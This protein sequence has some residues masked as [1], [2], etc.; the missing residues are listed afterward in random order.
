MLA[1]ANLPKA[2]EHQLTVQD[3]NA[4]YVEAIDDD[5]LEAWPDF[6]TEDGRYRITTAENVAQN[7]PLGMM[8]A[9]SRAM[10]RD[11]V[12][13][14]RDANVYETQRYRHV[15]GAPRVVSADG[16]GIRARTGF[17][18]VRIMHTGE[19]TIFATGSYEDRVLLDA[20]GGTARFAEKTVVLDS[21]AIDTLLAIPL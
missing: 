7:L 13:A 11:R 16:A 3:L 21:R 14:L 10:L 4:R 19:M 1:V 17:I 12:R 20:A 9:T 2:L 8:Y 5:S 15:L 18:V 6:F